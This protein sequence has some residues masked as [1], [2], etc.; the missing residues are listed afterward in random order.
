MGFKQE[1]H[2]FDSLI[3]TKAFI[4]II[5]YIRHKFI[6]KQIKLVLPE[7]DTIKNLMAPVVKHRLI[8]KA[9]ATLPLATENANKSGPKI[10]LRSC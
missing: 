5:T 10:R 8:I 3:F 9:A 6:K 4:L 2:N 7:E 1:C